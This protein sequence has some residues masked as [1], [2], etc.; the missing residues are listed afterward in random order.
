MSKKLIIA[1]IISVFFV[2]GLFYLERGF[3]QS[4]VAT[5]SGRFYKF[6][7]L[8]APGTASITNVNAGPSINDSGLVAFTG[9]TAAGS[10][11]FT[12]DGRNPVRVIRGAVSG[13]TWGGFVQ[14]NN[15]NFLIGQSFISSVGGNTI[16][17]FDTNP[18]TPT[19]TIIAGA[20][21]VGFNDFTSIYPPVSINNNSQAAFNALNGTNNNLVTGI[22]TTF[23]QVTLPNAANTLRPMVAD[24]GRVILRAGGNSTDPI[25]LYEYNLSLPVDIATVSPNTFASL[26]QSPGISDDG[27]VIVFYGDLTTA[28]ATALQ[29]T[30]GP[31]IFASI[32]IGGGTR[33]TIRIAGRQIENMNPTMLPVGNLDGV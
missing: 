19:S 5:I 6:D 13:T 3:A 32:D 23:N 17:R 31:G 11:V 21:L 15:S 30:P 4:S 1:L 22:R 29:T 9:N 25:R 27:A 16:T 18:S 33:R 26:G 24:N 28:G 2:T 10:I 12:A 20:N 7:V 8:A 14:I